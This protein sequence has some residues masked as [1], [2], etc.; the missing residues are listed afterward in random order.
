MHKTIHLF[1][2]LPQVDAREEAETE[3]VRPSMR[4]EPLIGVIRNARSHRNNNGNASGDLPAGVLVATPEKRGELPTILADFAAKQVDCIAIDGGDGTVRDI[5][6]CGAG[7]FGDSWPDLII[8]PNGKTN[9]L[10]LD[11]GLPPG[12]SLAEAIAAV[13]RG[14]T[15]RRRPMVIAQR[16]NPA[17]Q[18]RGFIMGAGVFN[19]AIALGQ[20]SHDLGAFNAAAVGVTA[21]WSVLQALLGRAGNP[22]RRGTYMKLRTSDGAE[23]PHAGGLPADERFLVLA[24]TLANFPA[25]LDPFRGMEEPLRMAVL[26]N[27]RRGLLLRIGSLMRGNASDATLR[28]GAHLVGDETLEV[29]IADSFILDGEAFPSGHYILSAGTPLRFVVP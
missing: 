8:L 26:D 12:W 21:A 2:R 13:K 9:A 3:F 23:I 17:A 6:T 24:S 5:L 29:D 19:R 25:G 28:R 7:V 18:V 10:G 20:R 27:P 11:L 4:K 1:D 16:E 14:N 15:V 22:W